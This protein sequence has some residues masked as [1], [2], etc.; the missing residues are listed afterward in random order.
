MDII[1]LIKKIEADKDIAGELIIRADNKEIEIRDVL[2]FSN[3]A[4][5]NG[6][7]KILENSDRGY[8][9]AYFEVDGWKVMIPS[10]Y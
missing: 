8:K 6:I 9:L 10:R 3:M 5:T 1:E 2:T 7:E 4:I